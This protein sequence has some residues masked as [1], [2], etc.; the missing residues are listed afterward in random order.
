VSSIDFKGT[1]LPGAEVGVE[2][3]YFRALDSN[4]EQVCYVLSLP[5]KK[6]DLVS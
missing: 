5:K 6:E 2:H 3:G 4:F 1:V